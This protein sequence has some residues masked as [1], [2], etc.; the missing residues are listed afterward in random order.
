MSYLMY[1]IGVLVL[2]PLIGA[3]AGGVVAKRRG[4]RDAGVYRG[5]FY[6]LV[7]GFIGLVLF[8]LYTM[9]LPYEMRSEEWGPYRQIINPPPQ[10]VGWLFVIGGSLISTILCVAIVVRRSTVP[11]SNKPGRKR[12][13]QDALNTRLRTNHLLWFILTVAMFFFVPIGGHATLSS[14]L[15]QWCRGP[16]AGGVGFNLVFIVIPMLLIVG[17]EAIVAWVL[18]ALLMVA[19][20]SLRRRNRA[21]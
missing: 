17:A 20:P 3:I 12:S 16:V 18:Q 15:I 4:Q 19:F 7:G 10:S 2:A 9:T 5:L 6:G 8:W 1:L 13:V 21:S 14:A 11:S